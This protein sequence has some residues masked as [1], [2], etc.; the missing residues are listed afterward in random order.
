MNICE[1]IIQIKNYRIKISNKIDKKF[2]YELK[3]IYF[4]QYK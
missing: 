2:K 1:N 4:A 3:I